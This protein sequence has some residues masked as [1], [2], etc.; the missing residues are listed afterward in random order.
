MSA[1]IIVIFGAAVGPDGR[2]TPALTRR[3]AAAIAY[4]KNR[5][6]TFLVTGGPVSAATP[7]AAVMAAL[8]RAAGISDNRILLEPHARNTLDSVRRCLP[9]LS[10]TRRVTLCSD[11][12]HLPRCRWLFRLAGVRAATVAAHPQRRRLWPILRE[13]IALPVDTVCWLF[14]L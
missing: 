9:L 10:A 2:P 11:D 8:L 13:A 1:E 6:A 4:G 5:D 14:R 7:E 3:V 12:F